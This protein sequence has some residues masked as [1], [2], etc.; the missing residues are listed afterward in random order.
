M[1]RVALLCAVLLA[2]PVLPLAAQETT[3]APA[4]A[5]PEPAPKIVCAEPT[6]HFGE[7]D[8]AQ[9]VEHTFIVRNEGNLTLEI[10]RV[11]P[12]CGCT[13]VNTSQTSVPPGESTE[14]KARLSLRGRLGPQHKSIAVESND[15]LTPSLNLLLEGTAIAE[16]QVTPTQIFFGRITADSAVTGI[17]DVI[18]QGS[19]A[20]TITKLES[21]VPQL[22]VTNR[23]A[24]DGRGYKVTIATAP[25][26][27]RGTLRGNIHME[28]DHPKYPAFD[29]PASAFVVGEVSYAPEEIPLSAPADQGVM[30]YIMIRAESGQ[31]LTIESVESPDPNIVA[32]IIQMDPSGVRIELSNITASKELDGKPIRIVTNMEKMKEILIPFR[33]TVAPPPQI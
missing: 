20:V 26:L 10:T 13:V 17:V 19:N 16:L 31:S 6:F 14:I 15:P 2:L 9:D 8:N 4:A 21:S 23:P 25:P 29:I 1:R 30:R 7:M 3:P 32:R 27:D 11:K 12:T 28:T 5:N 22:T 33:V 18:V 24:D